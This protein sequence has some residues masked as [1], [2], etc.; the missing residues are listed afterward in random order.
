MV[1]HAS[2]PRTMD[3]LRRPQG[4]AYLFFPDKAPRPHA[5]NGKVDGTKLTT[6]H[7]S[8]TVVDRGNGVYDLEYEVELR[9]RNKEWFVR[10]K[11]GIQNKGVFHT[12]LNGFNFDTHV[13]RKDR[14]VQA[15]VYP[16]PTLACIEDGTTRFTVLSE[17]AQGVASLTDGTIDVWLDRRLGQDDE[18]GLGQGVEDNVRVRTT[19]RVVVEK[20]WR[21]GRNLHQRSGSRNNGWN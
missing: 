21:W 11:T 19:L 3:G 14:P 10:F 20:G 1:D 17:H 7:W 18:R 15:Q 16:M 2:I 9:E 8:R 13:F 5:E 4:E 6:P 12:D